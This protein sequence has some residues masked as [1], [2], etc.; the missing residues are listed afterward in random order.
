LRNSELLRLKIRLAESQLGQASDAVV[1]HPEVARLFPEMLFRTHCVARA[2]APL[3]QA[4]LDEVQSRASDAVCAG[5]SEYLVQHIVEEREHAAW[6]EEDLSFVGMSSAALAHRTPPS[7]VASAVGAHY[8]WI[9]HFHPVALLGYIAVLEGA[10]PRL[11]WVEDL[12]ARTKLP[13]QAFRT[14]K[15][16]ALVDAEHAKDLD[17]L[18]DRL[19]LERV[20]HDLL[21]ESAFLTIDA[22]SSALVEI[23]RRHERLERA[24]GL[25]VG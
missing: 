3:M 20:H 21:R 11:G 18:L 24:T 8:Y 25:P 16:H 22:L 6:I 5:M 4:A 17:R 2:S 1:Q 23:V 9:K 13:A 12:M 7:T 10:A 19:P 14:L 15:V